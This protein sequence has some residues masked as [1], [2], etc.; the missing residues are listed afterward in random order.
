MTRLFVPA[1]PI[2][3]KINERGKP[4]TF[5]WNGVTH[6]IERVVS[7]TE[8]DTGWWETTGRV[9]RRSITVLTGEKMCLL[10]CDL[11]T[12]TWAIS[13]LYD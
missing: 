13:R 3:V 9:W 4:L 6:K 8:I 10:C 7:D 12:G 5:V 1:Q 11:E 2:A